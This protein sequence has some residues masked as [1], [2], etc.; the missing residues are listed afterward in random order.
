MKIEN[1]NDQRIHVFTH[2]QW[3]LYDLINCKL[4]DIQWMNDM[5]PLVIFFILRHIL[6]G[7]LVNYAFACIAYQMNNFC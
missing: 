3:L 5:V 2:R 1:T 6:H 7:S 4:G